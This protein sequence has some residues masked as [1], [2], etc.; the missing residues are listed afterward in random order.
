MAGFP[1]PDP[2][3][4]NTAA[5]PIRTRM[6]QEL[7]VRSRING[8]PCMTRPSYTTLLQCSRVYV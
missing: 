4:G 3:P 7:G 5:T 1:S 2:D 8:K 6:K